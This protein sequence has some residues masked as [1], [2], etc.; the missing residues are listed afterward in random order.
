M[1][2]VWAISE[3]E[4]IGV[5]VCQ[6]LLNDWCVPLKNKHEWFLYEQ[7]CVSAAA[8][9]CLSATQTPGLKAQALMIPH[10]VF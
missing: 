7:R 1:N 8:L 2:E 5:C 4:T 6:D 9:T 3:T 10:T